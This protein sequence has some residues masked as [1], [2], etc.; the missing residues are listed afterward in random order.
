[1]G[2]FV[3]RRWVALR[4]DTCGAPLMWARVVEQANNQD[5]L[6]YHPCGEKVRKTRSLG[7]KGRFTGY[8]DKQSCL[9]RTR[10]KWLRLALK[11]KRAP[12]LS[13]RKGELSPERIYTWRYYWPQD[14][15]VSTSITGTHSILRSPTV[16]PIQRTVALY[17]GTVRW[18]A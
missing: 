14:V 13:S 10:E 18:R 3:E 9:S 17:S 11:V 4:L 8:S 7:Q 15:N 1:M 2:G 6:T 16:V 5:V 12:A